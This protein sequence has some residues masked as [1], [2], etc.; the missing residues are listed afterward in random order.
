MDKVLFAVYGTLRR[1]HGNYQY[2]LEGNSTFLGEHITEPK[3]TMYTTGGFPIV[4]TEGETPIHIE[5]F[6][7]TD[8]ETIHGVNQLEGFSGVKNSPDNWYDTIT[9]DTPYGPA[10]MFYQSPEKISSRSMRVIESGN[11]NDR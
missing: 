5:V 11:W 4:A 1:G 7:V 9:V 3:F 10:E 8:P 2:L 6:E